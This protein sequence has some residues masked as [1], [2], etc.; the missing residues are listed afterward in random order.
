MSEKRNL[1]SIY[2]PP[3]PEGEKEIM[4]LINRL[5]V[6]R[7]NQIAKLLCVKPSGREAFEY[8]LEDL[9]TKKDRFDVS[10]HLVYGKTKDDRPPRSTGVVECLW[11]VIHRIERIDVSLV[12]RAEPP[13][14]LFYIRKTI[15]QEDAE[16]GSVIE[17]T[18][19][20]VIVDTFVQES[21]LYVVPY[22]QERYFAR[23]SR[24]TKGNTHGKLIN[25]LVVNDMDVAE[26]IL[27]IYELEVPTVFTFVDYSRADGNGVPKVS[28]FK[29][30]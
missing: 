5:G 8:Y 9:Y 20:E 7:D 26:R 23:G 27:D 11:D 28:Y 13:A 16:D 30:E 18:S 22:L 24:D 1:G 25:N 3:V 6:V 29:A 2:I 4:D 14:D 17:K 21:N 12:E 15:A 19:H 10:G